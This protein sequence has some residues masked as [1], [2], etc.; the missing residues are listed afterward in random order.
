MRK[1]KVD[2]V[3][4]HEAV[5][6]KTYDGDTFKI[7]IDLDC[8]IWLTVSLRL[9]GLDCK[10]SRGRGKCKEGM[11][12]YKKVLR[13]LL[14]NGDGFTEKEIEN[15]IKLQKKRN[16]IEGK[17]NFYSIRVRTHKEGKYAGRYLGE[18]IILYPDG[19]ELNL[20]QYLLKHKMAVP[21]F[22]GRR[23]L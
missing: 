22:G 6:L 1:I 11:E 10:E 7:F 23:K 8:R 21:Y 15:K 18:V 2:D 14:I 19:K 4:V 12:V 20:N 17:L 13:M 3:H 5:I 9:Y 16:F